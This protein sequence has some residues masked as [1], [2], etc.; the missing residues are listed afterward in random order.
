MSKLLITFG[1][2]KTMWMVVM[3]DLPVDTKVAVKEANDFRKRIKQDGF[4]MMQYSVYTRHCPSKENA[5]VHERRVKKILPPDGEVRILRI[6]D[7]Q[8]GKM[9]IFHGRRRKATENA[10]AQLQM[11]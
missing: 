6:T 8:F 3:F 7:K 5:D 1:G 9:K 11:F 4:M 2:M 10:P